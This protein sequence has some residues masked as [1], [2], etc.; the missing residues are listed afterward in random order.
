[1][2]GASFLVKAKRRQAWKAHAARIESALVAQGHR[3]EMSGPWPPY[4]FVS[5]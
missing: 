2:T 5:K 4:H 1:M 3:L